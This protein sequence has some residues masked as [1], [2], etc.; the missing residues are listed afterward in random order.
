MT[1]IPCMTSATSAKRHISPQL[2]R[3]AAVPDE[4]GMYDA[5][6]IQRNKVT[7]DDTVEL[8]TPGK[9]GRAF[10]ASSLS[11]VQGEKIESAPHPSMY[12]RLKVPFPVKEGDIL[13][14][15][16]N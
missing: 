11:D 10:S 2:Y 3:T 16:G 7:K 8:I 15:G 14:L 5:L 1:Q 13:R 4:N 12:F 6:F 9:V